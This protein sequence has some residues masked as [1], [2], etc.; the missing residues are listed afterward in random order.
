[1]KDANL[2]FSISAFLKKE[3]PELIVK[4]AKSNWT[5][6]SESEDILYS[7][8]KQHE[9]WLTHLLT[10]EALIIYNGQKHI[11]VRNWQKNAG[12][13]VEIHEQKANDR[14]LWTTLFNTWE[15]LF[16]NPE[17]HESDTRLN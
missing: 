1:M 17:S 13:D 10:A 11:A 2:L 14:K 4:F 5:I 6:G 12:P 3:S 16:M 7:I 8:F 15:K 9:F